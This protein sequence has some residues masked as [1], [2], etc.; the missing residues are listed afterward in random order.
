MAHRAPAFVKM[1]RHDKKCRGAI[2]RARDGI[3]GLNV[4]YP[5]AKALFH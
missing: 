3:K 4:E 5:P 2:H 1:L